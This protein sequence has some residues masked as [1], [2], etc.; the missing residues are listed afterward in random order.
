MMFYLRLA[1]LVATIS[2][3][4]TQ[5]IDIKHLDTKQ[6]LIA[7]EGLA[8]FE[9]A[10]AIPRLTT[11]NGVYLPSKSSIQQ[12]ILSSWIRYY[13]AILEPLL[14]LIPCGTTV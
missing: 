6:M 10:A 9:M 11:L 8:C 14:G 2:L 12:F 1:V 5:S 3:R 13:S 4:A 7:K